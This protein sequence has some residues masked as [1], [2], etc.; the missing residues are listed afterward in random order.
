MNLQRAENILRS[1]EPQDV[2]RS[3]EPQGLG[4]KNHIAK[5]D[6]IRYLAATSM[7]V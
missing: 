4:F 5:V 7:N 2:F 6:H 1:L 3:P